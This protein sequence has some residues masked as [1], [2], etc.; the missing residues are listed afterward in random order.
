MSTPNGPPKGASTG[1]AIVV[2]EPDRLTPENFVAE[3]TA[4]ISQT[5]EGIGYDKISH[6]TYARMGHLHARANRR[7]LPQVSLML[8][9]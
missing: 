8:S 9:V 2:I 1:H 4:I 6:R 3:L 5:L 7:G